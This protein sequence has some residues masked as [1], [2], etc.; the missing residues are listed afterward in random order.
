MGRFLPVLASLLVGATLA[1]GCGDSETD[2]AAP[3]AAEVRKAYARAPAPL[4]EVHAQANELL[5]GGADAFEKRL[6]EL[7]GHPVVVNKWGSWCEP[8]RRELPY[9]QRQAVEHA[10]RVAFLG[11]DVLDPVPEA[12]A[13][14]EQVPLSYPS[15]RDED[16][17]VS[18]VFNAVASTPAT[19]FYDSK[20]EL[21]YMKQ[22][23]YRSERDL[24]RDIER[25]AR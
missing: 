3:P 10:E 22:G 25:Y 20:G 23:E 12:E 13:L 24:A 15:Y 9:F 5:D 2:S 18:A 1:A 11:V 4:R 7:R 19:A 16:L 8:C 17:K 21:A 6:R 14:L